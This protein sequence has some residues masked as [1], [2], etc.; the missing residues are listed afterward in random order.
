MTLRERIGID[1]G[2]FDDKEVQELLDVYDE[3]K[4][5]LE[6]DEDEDMTE[7]TSYWGKMNDE[8]NLKQTLTERTRGPLP[9]DRAA[10]QG[11]HQVRC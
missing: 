9:S 2:D 1:P 11:R 10:E 7:A 8:P 4:K 6:S 5:G 3:V